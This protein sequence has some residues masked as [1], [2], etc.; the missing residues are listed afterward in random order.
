MTYRSTDT[1]R[2]QEKSVKM[3]PGKRRCAVRRT[4][5]LFLSLPCIILLVLHYSR[6]PGEMPIG[7]HSSP[8]LTADIPDELADLLK[9]NPEMGDFVAAYPNRADY[10]AQEIDLS[11][12]NRVTDAL[13][14]GEVPLLMQWDLRWGYAPYGDDMIGLSGCGPTCLSMAYIYLTGDTSMHPAAM[15]EY[16][17]SHGYYSEYGTEW[18]LWTEGVLALGLSGSAIS[19]EE[20]AVKNT[21][22]NGGLI[23]CSMRPGDFTTTGH[24]ILIRGYDKN[25]FYVND[26][27]RKSNSDRQWSYEELSPQIKNLWSIR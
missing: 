8:F 1:G 11:S 15:A 25:G 13:A 3:R 27:N 14:A 21:L 7:S 18:S 24:F 6:Q 23:I 16:A 12:D 5:L 20:N 17:Y 19:L 2:T 26:P 4:A 10:P 22:D 9:H